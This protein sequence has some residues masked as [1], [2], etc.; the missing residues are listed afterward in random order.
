MCPNFVFVE[1][2]LG[3]SLPARIVSKTPNFV[4]V[5]TVPGHSLPARIVLTSAAL[6][7]AMFERKC[8]NV[9]LD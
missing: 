6:S 2:V 4:F 8:A 7:S 3:H 1:T 5:E 9:P